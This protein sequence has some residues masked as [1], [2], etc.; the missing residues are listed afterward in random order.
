MS[1]GLDEVDW[2]ATLRVL[3]APERLASAQGRRMYADAAS[4]SALASE[5]L[6][7]GLARLALAEHLEPESPLHRLRR[8]LLLM[9]FGQAAEAARLLEGTAG[10][11][12]VWPI[13]GRTLAAQRQGELKRAANIAAEAEGLGEASPLP[14]YLLA[15]AKARDQPRLA[16]R[17]IGQLRGDGAHAAAAELLAKAALARPAD[18]SKL[19][20]RELEA[21]RLLP[22]ASAPAARLRELAGWLE[23]SRQALEAALAATRAGSR[24]EELILLILGDR[25]GEQALRGWREIMQRLPGRP[26]VRRR[27]VAELTRHAVELAAADKLRD[28]LVLVCECARLEPAETVHRQNRAAIFTL[29]GEQDTAQNAWAELERHQL[30]LALLG[31]LDPQS[32]R[33]YARPHRMFAQQARLSAVDPRRGGGQLELGVFRREP[34]EGGAT[35]LAVNQRRLDEDPEQLRQWLHHTRAELTFAHVALPG[36]RTLL[37]PEDARAARGRIA[38][39]V[40][41]AGSLGV[42]VEGEGDRL[43]E[44]LAA[45]WQKLDA[46]SMACYPRVGGASGGKPD[47]DSE[48]LLRAHLEHLADTMLLCRQW[49]ADPR[50]PQLVDEVLDQL[51][52]EGAFYDGAALEAA[53]ADK[54]RP[55]DSLRYLAGSVR[56]FLE[57]MEARPARGMGE[58]VLAPPALRRMLAEI[59]SQLLLAL[60]SRMQGDGELTIASSATER[61]LELVAR[62]RREVG[63]TAAVEFVTAKVFLIG[64]RFDEARAAL[65]RFHALAGAPHTRAKAE[66][67]EGI[68]S[69][70]QVLDKQRQG[71]DRDG[72]SGDRSGVL[73][74][75]DG[76]D[77]RG[78]RRDLAALE[79]EI[80]RLPTSMAAYQRLAHALAGA[81]R[82]AEARACADRAIARCLS[83]Q[84]QLRARELD[85]EVAALEALRTLDA[86]AVQTF[87]RG[88]RA[89]A[90][91]VLE[92]HAA[93]TRASCALSYL[94]GLCLLAETR[95]P[96]AEAAFKDAVAACQ[97]PLHLAVLR[98]LAADAEAALLGGQRRAVAAASAEGRHG[99]AMQLAAL[100]IGG[101]SRPETCLLDVARVQLAWA[102]AAMAGDEPPPPPPI[103]LASQ[104]AW[105]PRLAAALGRSPALARARALAELAASLAP[106][107][108]VSAL[109]AKIDLV[110]QQLAITRALG[111]AAR[112]ME[113]ARWADALASLEAVAPGEGAADPR[114]GAQRALLLLKL[115]RFADAELAASRAGASPHL[116]RFAELACKARIATATRLL[117]SKDSAA[118]LAALGDARPVDPPQ[119]LELVYCRAFA[120]AQAGYAAVDAADLA[121]ARDAFVRALDTIDPVLPHAR[122]AGHDRLTGLHDKLDAEL[123]RLR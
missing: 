37:G 22:A 91:A 109:L 101:A 87:L 42:L 10:D 30:Q 95:R 75:E 122:T 69:M 118:A 44:I 123:E 102:V 51:R 103:T 121:R 116:A 54:D 117:R 70:T 9:R 46:A 115:E 99:Q 113:Q 112:L 61:A 45:R 34:S 100:M 43:A 110:E 78:A 77:G 108:S 18:G 105:Q 52:I 47:R 57:Q 53:L 68:E 7:A 92:M 76:E 12:L 28:A 33:S 56:L 23:A 21:H 1:L 107:D 82:F 73:E 31:R 15:D 16:D 41:M 67:G 3:A 48:R 62:A 59:S 85:L 74:G 60:A 65:E 104:G 63:S 24:Q 40:A 11:G 119:L 32:A 35:R 86:G 81:G 19:L 114:L 111:D 84:G 79:E 120:L 5:D 97:R 25:L 98:P 88:A 2:S 49:R 89:P 96:E 58:L 29:L 39:L 106:D 14:R 27:F 90:L 50:R 13:I 83:R 8:A 66:F 38:A 72:V 4:L 64:R 71:G 6:G 94:R 36:P 55:A 26:A 80:E 20:R 17:Q 93:I